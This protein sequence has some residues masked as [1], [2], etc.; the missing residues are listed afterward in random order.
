MKATDL[1]KG[2]AISIDG[3]IWVV[4]KYEHTKPGKGPAYMATTL[5]NLLTGANVQR[6][7][8]SSDN[9]QQVVLD[10]R[11]AEYLYPE[12]DTYVFM[13]TEDFEQFNVSDDLVGEAMKYIKSNGTCTMLFNDGNPVQVE[14]PPTVELEVAE[15]EPGVKGA[16]VTNVQKEAVMET[17]LKT[18]VP[19]FINVGEM[20]KLSTEDGSYLSR[21]KE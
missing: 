16:T 13:D 8:G 20:L 19:D 5:K 18:R 4:V 3:Q 7:F 21:V 14:L 6:R 11:E 1:K 2:T 17:G 9:V 12:G 15:C 10:R